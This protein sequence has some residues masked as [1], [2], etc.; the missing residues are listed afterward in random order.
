MVRAHG[1]RLRCVRGC[2]PVRGGEGGEERGD[3][4]GGDATGMGGVEQRRHR[5]TLIDK[6]AH[7]AFRGGK[8]EGTSEGGEGL[9]KVSLRL[10]HERTED[11][12][13]DH[14]IP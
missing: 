7:V 5:G 8:C 14:T 3:I 10:E 6:D 13:F 11:E 2:R 4:V 9:L 1:S 12:D